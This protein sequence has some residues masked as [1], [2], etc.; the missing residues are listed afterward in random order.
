MQFSRFVEFLTRL[1]QTGSRLQIRQILQ[2]LFYEIKKGKD[3]NSQAF[4]V[5]YFLVGKLT[6]DFIPLEF[7]VSNK[8]VI[9]IVRSFFDLPDSELKELMSNLGDLGDIWEEQFNNYKGKNK[10]FKTMSIVEL[11]KK[12]LD[13]A[14][15]SGAGSNKHKTQL[16]LDLLKSLSPKEGKY[17]IRFITKKLRLGLNIRSIIDALAYSNLFDNNQNKDLLPDLLKQKFE[18]LYGVTSDIGLIVYVAL[19]YNKNIGNILDSIHALPGVPIAS[20]LAERVKTLKEVFVRIP[21]PALEPKYDGL[22]GQVHGFTESDP[23]DLNSELHFIQDISNRIWYKAYI[24]VLKKED[25]QENLFVKQKNNNASMFIFSRNAN[26]L[27]EMFPEVKSDI[28]KIIEFLN[29]N[30]K[31]FIQTTLY[32]VLKNIKVFNLFWADNIDRK[33]LAKTAYLLTYTQVSSLLETEIKKIKELNFIP[34][35]ILDSEIIGYDENAEEYIPF[36]QTI[37]RRR[38]YNIKDAI[39]EVPVHLYVFDLM[40]LGYDLIKLPFF[41]RRYVLEELFKNVK[42]LNYLKLTPQHIVKFNGNKDILNLFEYYINLGLE[43]IMLKERFALYRPGIR[44]FSWIKFKRAMKGEL[45]DSVDVVVLGY[46]YGKGK[47]ASLGIGALLLGVYDSQNDQFLTITKL[48]T[49][50]T[51]DKWIE[52]KKL[53]DNYK[54]DKL[55]AMVDI[56]KELLPDVFVVPKVVITVEADEITKSPVHTAGFALRFPR[57]KEIRLD[58]GPTDATTLKEIKELYKIS[59]SKNGSK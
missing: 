32:N 48:G 25:R 28:N 53:L 52:I 43:G 3:L 11:Y 15:I 20:A 38:K 41:V 9:S 23:K 21:S 55:P 29:N 4:V 45:A 24:Y 16:I 37:T 8:M 26:N 7:G 30:G 57:F 6:P 56:N 12:L 46:Y 59:K 10:G 14:T 47:R 27:T 34:G 35:I 22:R 18:Y 50:L 1:E 40:F 54:V 42:D 17:L 2:E 5:A 49:G 58:K 44:T 39:N 36:Q 13:I 19:K 51:D 31:D 33:Q